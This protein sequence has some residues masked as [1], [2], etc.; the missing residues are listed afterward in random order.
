LREAIAAACS[1]L[2]P[3][4]D[5]SARGAS[6]LQPPFPEAFEREVEALHQEVGLDVPDFL[7]HR[8]LLDVGGY[9]EQRMAKQLG[10]DFRAHVRAARQR[11]AAAGCPVPAVEA[12]ALYGWIRE[13][14]AGCIERP[15]QRP[16]TWTDR[17][18]RILTHRLWGTL[19][20]LIVMF[21]VFQ[22]IFTW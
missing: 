16:V 17:L 9:V 4:V 14:T 15:A 6:G 8:L 18:D 11:L 10:D 5:G 13:V 2:P 7:V 19:L 21:L 1:Q 20:F 22:S 12:R 3:R